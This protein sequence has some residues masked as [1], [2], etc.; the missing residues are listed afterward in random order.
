MNAPVVENEKLHK[1]TTLVLDLEPQENAPELPKATHGSGEYKRHSLAAS[2]WGDIS[3]SKRPTRRVSAEEAQAAFL[4]GLL[5]TPTDRRQ[6]NLADWIVSLALHIVIIGTVVVAP[7]AFTQVIDFRNLAANVS[8]GATAAR[9]CPTA[10][11][12][13]AGNQA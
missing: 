7:L 13:P 12:G 10:S 6:R 3:L 4:R 11:R 2:Y 9:C 1:P 5:D 8:H